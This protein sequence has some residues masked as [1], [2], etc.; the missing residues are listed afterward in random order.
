MQLAI[1]MVM[2]KIN[3]NRHLGT[4][5]SLASGCNRH[6]GATKP[7][8]GLSVA[9]SNAGHLAGKGAA[10]HMGQ[11]Y[12][13]SE[14]LFRA[15]PGVL[16]GLVQVLLGSGF[17]VAR[18]IEAG[19][20]SFVQADSLLLLAPSRNEGWRKGGGV[21][22]KEEGVGRTRKEGR[23]RVRKGGARK[24]RKGGGAGR[25]VVG[26]EGRQRGTRG[27]RREGERET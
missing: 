17:A 9:F 15:V 1:V 27:A 10:G 19:N 14:Q 4:V 16:I 25:G 20:Y 21:R 8:G 26:K 2:I 11:H 18:S 23:N 12:L 5:T 24:E 7:E 6:S 3:L 13:D 22:K